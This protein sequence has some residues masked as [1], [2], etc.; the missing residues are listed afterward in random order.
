MIKLL[1]ILDALLENM[2]CRLQLFSLSSIP[3]IYLNGGSMKPPG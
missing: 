1:S 3:T 2:V